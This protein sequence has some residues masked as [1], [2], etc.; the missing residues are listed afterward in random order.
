M[1]GR[2]A[3]LMGATTDEVQ[4]FINSGALVVDED[5]TVHFPAQ[6]ARMRQVQAAHRA[7]QLDN[8]D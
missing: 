2:V 7:R 8:D 1:L 3:R 6:V 5:G 4:K